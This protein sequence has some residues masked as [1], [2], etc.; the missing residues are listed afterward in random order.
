MS[1]ATGVG[2]VVSAQTVPIGRT[3]TETG[4]ELLPGERWWGGAVGR[5]FAMPF[6]RGDKI[7]LKTQNFNNQ[8]VGLL[9]SNKGRYVWSERPFAFEVGDQYLKISSQTDQPKVEIGGTTLREAYMAA[10]AKYFPPSGTLPDP[11]F[12]EKP[13]YNTWIELQYNQNQADVLKYAR[14]IIDNGLPPGVLMIDDSWQKDFGEWEFQPDKFPDPRAMVDELHEMGFKVMLWVVPFVSPDSSEY[15]DLAARKLLV[16]NR[17][18]T[19][20]AVIDWWNGQSASYDMTCYE[21][22]KYFIAK[23]RSLQE[24]YGVDGFK[25]DGGDNYFYN[26]LNVFDRRDGKMG[27]DH[28]KAFAQIGL[29]FPFN[30]YRA[31]WQMGN[32]PLVQRLGDKALSWGDLAKLVPDAAAAG[33]LG[34]AFVCP[35]M[36]GG[37]SIGS[38]MGDYV[39]SL[40]QELVVRSA[41]V[42]AMMPMMQFSVAPWRV[43]DERHMAAVKQAAELHTRFA[44]YIMQCAQASALSGEPIVRNMEY[45]FPGEGFEDCRDQ[46]MLGDRYLVAPIITPRQPVET[47]WSRATRIAKQDDN[48]RV[49]PLMGAREV[50]LPRGRWRD[51]EGKVHRGSRTIEVIAPLTRV[52]YFEKL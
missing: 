45:A 32:Q 7:D 34:Y 8:V 13:Q 16:L 38:F 14:G 40:D 21:A 39:A 4:I 37:G 18:G 44:P 33:L 1:A 42:H 49:V 48:M 43:L 2:A 9:L 31:G 23:L 30:E 50:R 29:E 35:D 20:P 46:Y 5:G 12:F 22:R 36:V 15:R 11:M 3:I 6:K 52:P 25:F 17:D 41:Q 47:D 28:T 24:R 10:S 19:R 26:P 27:V 51:D